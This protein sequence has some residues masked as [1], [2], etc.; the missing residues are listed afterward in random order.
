MPPR[1]TIV[2]ILIWDIMGAIRVWELYPRLYLRARICTH[3]DIPAVPTAQEVFWDISMS[4]ALISP[5]FP[6]KGKYF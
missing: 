6:S 5:C 3:K 1:L 4:Y 2:L